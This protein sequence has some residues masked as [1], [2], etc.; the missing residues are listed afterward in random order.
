MFSISKETDYALGAINFLSKYNNEYVSISLISEKLNIS[1]KYLGRILPKI[2]DAKIVESK[3]GKNGGY[4]LVKKMEDISLYDFLKIF[5][6]DLDFVKCSKTGHKCSCHKYCEQK[7]FFSVYLK[8]EI[9]N[10]LKK[11]KINEIFKSK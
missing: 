9:K 6:T 2:A 4:I 7:E 3:E 10:I 11:K 8:E 5:E 1:K